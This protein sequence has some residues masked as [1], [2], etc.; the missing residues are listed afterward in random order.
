MD[1]DAGSGDLGVPAIDARG[2][3]NGDH[4]SLIGDQVEVF[5]GPAYPQD[6]F[7]FLEGD[8]ALPVDGHAG[9]FHLRAI[10]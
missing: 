4:P 3:R 9:C 5:V 1:P 8:A 2:G 6:M 7:V 10:D